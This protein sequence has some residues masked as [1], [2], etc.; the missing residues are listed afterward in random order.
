MNDF[1]KFQPKSGRFQLNLLKNFPVLCNFLKKKIFKLRVNYM[2]FVNI[3]QINLLSSGI[4]EIHFNYETWKRCHK[5]KLLNGL[6][7]QSARLKKEILKSFDSHAHTLKLHPLVVPRNVRL[8]ENF[9]AKKKISSLLHNFELKIVRSREPKNK[10]FTLWK[11]STFF[12][13]VFK[14]KARK[15]FYKYLS[16]WNISRLLHNSCA[17]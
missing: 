13:L 4:T 1:V 7:W 5:T 11:I 8:Q 16:N 2:N 17:Y 9:N 3:K 10:I 15:S 14:W 12:F 6:F